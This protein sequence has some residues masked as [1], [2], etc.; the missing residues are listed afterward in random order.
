MKKLLLSFLLLSFGFA[1]MAQEPKPTKEQTI[2]YITNNLQDYKWDN[3]YEQSGY[4]I[5]VIHSIKEITFKDDNLYVKT[6][7]YL[8][9]TNRPNTEYLE[10]YY[11]NLKEIEKVIKTKSEKGGCSLSL[12]SVN[13]N[14]TI[15]YIKSIISPTTTSDNLNLTEAQI[16]C[17]DDYKL[18]HAL[19][20]LR[21]LCGA[22]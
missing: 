7:H 19:N 14:K 5:H 10:E 15:K 22:Q 21:K 4:E 13:S 16:C 6:Y 17:P 8:S 2:Q 3:Q 1:V 12:S 20:H 11:I 18:V 9:M